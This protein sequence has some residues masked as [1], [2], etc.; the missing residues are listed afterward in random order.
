MGIYHDDAIMSYIF[1]ADYFI[2]ISHNFIDL[3]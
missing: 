1:I 2:V 3:K